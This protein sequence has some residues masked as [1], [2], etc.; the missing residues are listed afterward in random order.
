MSKTAFKINFT[1]FKFSNH[2]ANL[3]YQVDFSSY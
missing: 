2:H 3:H 1:D